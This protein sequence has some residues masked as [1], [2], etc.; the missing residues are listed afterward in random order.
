[1]RLGLMGGTFN[2]PHIGHMN[3]ALAA[4]ENIPLDKII[5]IPAGTPPHKTM[6]E[7][8]ASAEQRFEMTRLCADIIGADVSD[9]EI[10][11]EG[12]SYTI[13]TLKEIKSLF[14]DDELWLIVG[15]DMF[16]SMETWR[17]HE[18]IFSLISLAV[19][20]RKNSDLQEL[21]AHS[22]KLQS[23]YGVHSKIIETEAITISSSE[24]R[25]DS[26][27]ETMKKFLPKP[28]YDYIKEQ[29]LYNVSRSDEA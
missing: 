13:D 19:I 15:T 1:M 4:K 27:G 14:P 7:N 16:L 5:L 20:P 11:R 12:R 22:E 10:R 18:K 29:G 6:A 25:P 8:S 21:T 3:A 2:P 17:E 26:G 9:I 28:V 23:K 24:I